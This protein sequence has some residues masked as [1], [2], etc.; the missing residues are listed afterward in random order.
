MRKTGNVYKQPASHFLTL[1]TPTHPV[2]GEIRLPTQ[3]L[4]LTRVLISVDDAG[5]QSP[6]VCHLTKVVRSVRTLVLLP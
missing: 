2:E 6:Y 3:T 1:M 5:N 4:A